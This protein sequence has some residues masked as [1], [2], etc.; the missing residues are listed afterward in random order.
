MLGDMKID[1]IEAYLLDETVEVFTWQVDRPGSGDGRRPDKA[2]SIVLR[3]C[4]DDG[5]E[6]YAVGAKGRIGMDL[7]ERRIAP[8]LY[9]KDPTLTE[10]L[11]ERVWDI[12][13]LEEFPLYFLGLADQAL[14]DLKGRM[15][16]L[17]VYKLLGGYRDRI[18]AYASTTSYDTEK[19]YLDIIGASLE[20]GYRSV[21]LHLRQ[22]DV[23]SNAEL[24]RAVRKFVGDGFSLTLDASAL[25]NF[26]DSLWFGKVLEE[27]DF[28][29]YEE[30][31]REFDLESYAK[32]C[33]DLTIPILAAECSD[34][35]HWNAAEF[36]RRGACDIMRT[37]T[38]YKGGFT[39]GI[40]VGHLAESF[41]MKAEVHGGGWP[42][43]QLGLALANNTYYEDLVISVDQVRRKKNG[44]I[45]FDRGDVMIPPGTVGVG[46]DIDLADVRKRAV[47]SFTYPQE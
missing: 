14:W 17:P 47:A 27:L 44:A 1:R 30:P 12:D 4:T 19:E 7:V 16:G 6:G 24:C 20:E 26:T 38:H 36:I 45:P 2:F 28:E 8:E 22:R 34:G 39:G 13:R 18:P 46:W 43:L 33:H 21:K 3:I 35:A 31:M 9:G 15:A 25:W 37:S 23:K 10:F 32:L 5:V 42:N 29:W 41:G 11:W 40:K